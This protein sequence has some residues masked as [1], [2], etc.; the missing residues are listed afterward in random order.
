[1][2]DEYETRAEELCSTAPIH[3]RGHDWSS[4]GSKEEL[5]CLEA[6]E[7]NGSWEIGAETADE[8]RVLLVPHVAQALRSQAGIT[9]PTVDRVAEL[10]SAIEKTATPEE[11]FAAM[12]DWAARTPA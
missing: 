11:G 10:A 8:A 2:S 7:L 9:E 4:P 6:A 3:S 1:M 5:F 12:K